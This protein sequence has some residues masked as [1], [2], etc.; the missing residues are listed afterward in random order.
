[1]CL[2]ENA[3]HI[4]EQVWGNDGQFFEESA[5]TVTPEKQTAHAAH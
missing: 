1:M 3:R 5:V 2:S 4:L